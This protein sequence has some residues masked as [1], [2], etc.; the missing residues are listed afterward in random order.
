[1]NALIQNPWYPFRN[2]NEFK[3]AWFFVEANV[4]WERVES[5]LK[6]SLAPLDVQFTSGFTLRALL[7]NL[8]G[9]LG[10]ES[11]Q[12]RHGEANFSGTKV[13]IYYQDPLECIKYLIRQRTYQS[14]LVYSPEHLYE[15]GERQYGELHMADWWWK[16]Q[17]CRF[18]A[19]KSLLYAY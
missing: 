5:F 14:D 8:G 18:W 9:S 10:P 2:A 1:M 13:S 15:N 6:A 11:C 7:N 4:P 12:W 19:S 16:T 17:V 3:L